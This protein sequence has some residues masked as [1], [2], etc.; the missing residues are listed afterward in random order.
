MSKNKGYVISAM[1]IAIGI[2]VIYIIHKIIL[3]FSI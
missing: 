3:L 2:L 1:W